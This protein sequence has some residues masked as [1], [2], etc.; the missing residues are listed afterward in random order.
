V[1]A[2]SK[3]ILGLWFVCLPTSTPSNV[4]AY[5]VPAAP[6]IFP[7]RSALPVR[8]PN[9]LAYDIEQGRGELSPGIMESLIG[10]ARK[11]S[12]AASGPTAAGQGKL[13]GW[14][15]P[16][17]GPPSCLDFNLLVCPALC[18]GH[19][20]GRAGRKALFALAFRRHLRPLFRYC[21]RPRDASCEHGP[22]RCRLALI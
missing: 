5:R 18:V 13:A 15:G 20:F 2:Q 3:A 4:V 9:S 19:H 7:R 14:A 16:R 17:A 8:W 1:S 12:D 10:R 11:S 22:G 6:G 21:G